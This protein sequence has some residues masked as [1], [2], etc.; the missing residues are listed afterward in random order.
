MTIYKYK[1][2]FFSEDKNPPNYA[3]TYP[4]SLE[5]INNFVEKKKSLSLI[6]DKILYSFESSFIEISSIC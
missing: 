2:V 6:L 3:L 1:F 5:L 4:L